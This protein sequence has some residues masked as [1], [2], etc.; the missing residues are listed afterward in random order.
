[1]KRKLFNFKDM[2]KPSSESIA[3]QNRRHSLYEYYGIPVGCFTS[4]SEFKYTKEELKAMT[5]ITENKPV[6][7]DL[8]KHLLNTKEERSKRLPK[9]EDSISLTLSK[10]EEQQ[11]LAKYKK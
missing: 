9:P 6:P 2:Y 1:M 4:T 10:E 3:E 8:E 11:I 7:E 5:Y